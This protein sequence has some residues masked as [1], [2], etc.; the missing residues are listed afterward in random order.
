VIRL[1]LVNSFHRVLPRLRRACAA[2]L[3]I[4]LRARTVLLSTGHFTF[5][6][7]RHSRP[8]SSL[9]WIPRSPHPPAADETFHR[10]EGVLAGSS[11]PGACDLTHHLSSVLGV[12]DH[13][14]GGCEK[15]FGVGNHRGLAPSITAAARSGAEI[16][17]NTLPLGA[18]VDRMSS[19]VA[20]HSA[21][22]SERG[23]V[24]EPLP[25]RAPLSRGQEVAAEPQVHA[26]F[27][28]GQT[29]GGGFF[30]AIRWPSTFAGPSHK[31]S[32]R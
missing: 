21:E 31:R 8:R 29:A 32:P 17:A 14:R 12:R 3:L 13:R 5:T 28:S 27:D 9:L 4:L 7:E 30:S 11:P 2:L 10:I 15:P 23:V 16:N 24:S 6:L 22:A 20:S 25:Y 1:A 26:R 19:F 18:S